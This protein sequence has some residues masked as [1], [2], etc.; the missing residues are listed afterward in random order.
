MSNAFEDVTDQEERQS[1]P[2]KVWLSLTQAVT[3]VVENNCR[4]DAYLLAQSKQLEPSLRRKWG[5]P[6]PDWLLPHLDHLRR[7]LTPDI[8]GQDAADTNTNISKATFADA[9]RWLALRGSTA[10]DAYK[11]VASIVQT[12]K[13]IE[14]GYAVFYE[15]LRDQCSAGRIVLLGIER[16][17]SVL[18]GRHAPIP[19]DFFLRPIFHWRGTQ[20]PMLSP[21]ASGA[22]LDAIFAHH[23]SRADYLDVRI[24]RED[25]EKLKRLFSADRVKAPRAATTKDAERKK[26][27]E[28]VLASA[29]V[30][31]PAPLSSIK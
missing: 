5:S 3:W 8:T 6:E 16:H 4:D 10:D 29:L 21:N 24:R 27:I 31:W 30:R 2:D 23:D 19:S 20:E 15:L 9:Q 22:S 14:L 28:S 17:K 25:V 7:G 11:E 1:P 26:R 13:A 18:A 12:R